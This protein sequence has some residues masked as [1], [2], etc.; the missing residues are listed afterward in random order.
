LKSTQTVIFTVIR[1][2]SGN[3]WAG[4]TATLV[5][6]STNAGSTFAASNG[7]LAPASLYAGSLGAT[8]SAIFFG[9]NGGKIYK[10]TDGGNTWSGSYNTGAG[11][12]AGMNDIFITPSNAILVACDSGFVYSLDGITWSK[13]NLGLAY[14]SGNLSDQLLRVTMSANNII[15][16]TKNGK[17]YYR[18]AAQVLAGI[19]EYEAASV[20]SKA[21]PNPATDL[22]T[23][24]S[25]ELL[26]EKNCEVIV[27][28]VLGRNISTIE[29]KNGE[30][31][32]NVSKFSKGIYS[33]TVLN[34]KTAV[35]KGKLVV[36]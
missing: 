5:M 17:V 36:N 8:S 23:I 22:V 34:N 1:G 31:Q 35:S 26:N 7:T 2:I 15:V 3:L 28:D 20:E 27:T 32:F 10:S 16:S 24:S 29:M 11:S 4:T 30:A 14:S 6:K 13:N 18:P 12:S 25:T 9:T 33:Y 21:Y 19:K